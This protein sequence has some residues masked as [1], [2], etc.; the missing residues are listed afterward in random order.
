M[1]VPEKYQSTDSLEYPL[2]K[3]YLTEFELIDKMH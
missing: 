1:D 2:A 3:R